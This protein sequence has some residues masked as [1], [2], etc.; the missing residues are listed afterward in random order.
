[1][2]RQLFSSLYEVYSAENGKEGLQKIIE[3]KPDLVV[4]D[5]MMPVMDGLELCR[6]VKERIDICHI[7]I[8]LLTALDTA[9][10]H[11]EGLR[12]GADDYIAKPFDGKMLLARCNNIIRNRKLL[13]NRF[14][15]KPDT[16]VSLLATNP[17]DKEFLEHVISVVDQHLAEDDFDIAVVYQEMC[18]C[19]TL[20]YEKFKA[21]AGVTPNE[22]IMQHKLKIAAHKLAERQ[23]IRISDIAYSLGFRSVRYF[24]RCFKK[25]YDIPP[26][27]YREEHL[28]KDEE[29]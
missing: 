10:Q 25:V 12:S 29:E 7:P 22:F 17:I 9:E 3:I 8:V 4:S 2:L 6:T 27:Q 18:I 28:P 16:D 24:S 19:K 1:M 13:Q 20:F 26:A 11:I 14:V 23:E 15:N 21:L 5:I